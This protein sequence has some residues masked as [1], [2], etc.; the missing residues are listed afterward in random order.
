MKK[1]MCAEPRRRFVRVAVATIV[2]P[3]RMLLAGE[4]GFWNR[5]DPSEWTSDEVDR[6]ITKSPWAKEVTAAGLGSRHGS[7]QAVVRWESAR[8]VLEALK[9]PLPR[10]L[11]GHYVISV[12]GMPFPAA[13]VVD[14]AETGAAER[15]RQREMEFIV[16]RITS[17]TRL[18]VK[19]AATQPA[20]VQET[21]FGVGETRTL[22]YGFS[23]APRPLSPAD[24]EVIFTTRI[25]E[26]LVKAT[27]NLREMMYRNELA[28]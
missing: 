3:V 27:F 20:I 25:G 8:P 19:G 15:A 7:R 9:E 24:S 6:L 21:P 4:S 18:E 26:A 2:A 16:N 13:R 12:S 10:E 23:K 11:T 14:P 1:Q 22:L 17:Q 28:L 5:K